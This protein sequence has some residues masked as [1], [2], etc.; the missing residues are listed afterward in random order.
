YAGNVWM[1]PAPH[2]RGDTVSGRYDSTSGEMRSDGMGK[3]SLL[4]GGIV[5]IIGLVVFVQGILILFG[6]P[7]FLMPLRVRTGS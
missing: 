5:A 7:E 4:I 1:R 2:E 6:I 3:K